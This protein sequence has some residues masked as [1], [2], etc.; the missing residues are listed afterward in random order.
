MILDKKTL[1]I[2]GSLEKRLSKYISLI[3]KRLPRRFTPRND[4]NFEIAQV[5][6]P[7]DVYLVLEF[8]G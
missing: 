2:T 8:D 5:V 1:V 4:H 7:K 6:L 3:F